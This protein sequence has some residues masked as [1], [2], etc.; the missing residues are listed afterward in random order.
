MVV[1]AA[2]AMARVL[3]PSRHF[4]P[5]CSVAASRRRW[6]TDRSTPGSVVMAP[7]LVRSNELERRLLPQG[8]KKRRIG[9]D[10]QVGHILPRTAAGM[11]G[12]TPVL[13]DAS[14]FDDVMRIRHEVR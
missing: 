6:S 9:Q 2:A 14:P 8:R 3:A 1:P 11:L 12:R 5:K 4:W 10:P 7:I 13:G